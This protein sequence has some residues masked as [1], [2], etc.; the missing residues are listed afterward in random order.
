MNITKK[1]ANAKYFKDLEKGAV[2][3]FQTGDHIFMKTERIETG[4]F[5]CNTVDLTN[6]SLEAAYDT[7]VVIPLEHEL[8]I[9]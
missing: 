7:A 5:C 4:D 8:I 3:K 1:C 6:G 9:R 2:F